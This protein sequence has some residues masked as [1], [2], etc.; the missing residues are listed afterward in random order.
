V[1]I[2]TWEVICLTSFGRNLFV[3]S[4]GMNT[5]INIGG[6]CRHCHRQ[7]CQIFR[8]GKVLRAPLYSREVCRGYLKTQRQCCQSPEG[9]LRMIPIP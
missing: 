8:E 2:L 4:A 9:G 5:A 7:L 6:R 3:P 1:Q